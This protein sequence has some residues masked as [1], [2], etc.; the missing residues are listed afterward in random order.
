ML[1]AAVLFG[2]L[3][4]ATPETRTQKRAIWGVS[5]RKH[6][7]KSEMKKGSEESI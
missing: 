7:R 4:K 5:P 6:K 1:Y 2:F 3:Q